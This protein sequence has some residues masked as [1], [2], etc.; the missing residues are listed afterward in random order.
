MLD[1]GE[2]LLNELLSN[3]SA[4]GDPSALRSRL[5]D[6][7]MDT[8]RRF[9][10]AWGRTFQTI[11]L[12]TRSDVIRLGKR[13]AEVE[14]GVARIEAQLRRIERAVAPEARPAAPSGGAHPKRTRRPPSQRDAV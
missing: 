1:N 9:R 8:R 5:L 10:D 12:P 11:N 13:I 2:R 4:E 14:D 6:A 7:S 3:R